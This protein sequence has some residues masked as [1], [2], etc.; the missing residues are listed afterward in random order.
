MAG[1]E[2]LWCETK[3]KPGTTI[4]P[5]CGL[6][7]PAGSPRASL[8]EK[9]HTVVRRGRRVV[10]AL[11]AVPLMLSA[12]YSAGIQRLPIVASIADHTGVVELA[13]AQAFVPPTY[14][15]PLQRSVWVDGV[16][17]IR[18]ALG[19]PTY[20]AFDGSYVNV[21][22][23]HIVTFCGVVAGTSGYDSASGAER[24]ISVFG[25]AQATSLEG[26]DPSFGVLWNRVCTTGVNAV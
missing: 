4:C 9:S 20:T 25:Q 19:Q 17:S 13:S 10:L 23:G 7:N 12:A 8:K 26:T 21:T 1:V 11:I 18:Q 2:C 22:T 24:F 5:E 15:D 14:A 3:V 16:K 6:Q